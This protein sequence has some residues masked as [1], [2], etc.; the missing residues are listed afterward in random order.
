MGWSHTGPMDFAH[1]ANS[2]TKQAISL[3]D[4]SRRFRADSLFNSPQEPLSLLKIQD[5]AQKL[6]SITQ[7]GMSSQKILV[8]DNTDHVR[9]SP[10]TRAAEKKI[11]LPSWMVQSKQGEI[12]NKER[13]SFP[14]FESNQQPKEQPKEQPKTQS[15]P[16]PFPQNNA[17]KSGGL[18]E[19]KRFSLPE[20]QG[21]LYRDANLRAGN[22]ALTKLDSQEAAKIIG[23][24]P[25]LFRKEGMREL[26]ML[27]ADDSK[28]KQVYVS[29]DASTYQK[30]NPGK[31]V[32]STIQEA[33]NKAP[34][35]SVINVIAGTNGKAYTESVSVGRSDLTIS[36]NQQSPAVIDG[37]GFNIGSNIHDVRILNFD[38]R[39]F[40]GREAAI[41]VEGKNIANIVVGGNYF[42]SAVGS[43]AAGFY[44]TG[45]AEQEAMKNVYLV[46]N[47][48]GQDRQGNSKP[49]NITAKQL[50]AT[51]FNGN[52]SDVVAIG[53]LYFGTKDTPLNL[54]MDFIG[55]EN[56]SA[57]SELNRARNAFVAFNYSTH[58]GHPQRWAS[59]VAYIDGASRITEVLNMAESSNFCGE[60][61]AER[62]GAHARDN[63]FSGNLCKDIQNYW[64]TVGAPDN[65]GA[66][67]SGSKIQ[68]NIIIKAN[69]ADADAR[70]PQL[71]YNPGITKQEI[72]SR[73]QF[74]NKPTDVTTLPQKIVDLYRF[75]FKK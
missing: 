35:D 52:V 19:T 2:E 61:G 5:D 71:Q 7:A 44:G 39:N 31:V 68:N 54:G 22:V 74:F 59:G 4:E 36:T 34:K 53:N 17:E 15:N 46:G 73:N 57:N 10:F 69:N 45:S 18:K 13:P 55:G 43:E 63:T 32:F 51:P 12:A 41:R 33:V 56:V 65:N 38:F 50:E 60:I 16:F 37:G 67:V 72:I 21:P 28:K 40:T 58:I 14:K 47:V 20:E 30:Q 9:T 6:N 24:I 75:H 48:V 8:A 11:E 26:T 23:S 49:L 64:I 1:S 42:Y 29:Q 27:T 62:P 70:A 66:K 3:A 25:E